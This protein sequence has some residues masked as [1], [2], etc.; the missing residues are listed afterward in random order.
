MTDSASLSDVAGVSVRSLRAA[1]GTALLFTTNMGLEDVAVDEWARRADAAG[2]EVAE[3]SP[4]T[5][6]PLDLN[7]YALVTVQAPLAAALEVARSMR[8][9]HHVRQPLYAFDL[10]DGTPA[11]ASLEAIREVLAAVEVPGMAEAGTFRVTSVRNGEHDFTSIDVQRASGTGLQRQ[12]ETEVDLE[13][14]DLD[15]HVDVH[16]ARCLVSVQHT[17]EA[18][19][20]RQERLFE[21]HAGLKPNVAYGLL[22]LPRLDA[23]PAVFLD[24][25]CGSGTLLVEAAAEWPDADLYGNDWDETVVEG[26][27]T[28]LRAEG[29]AGRVE[30]RD[31]DVWHLADAFADLAGTVDL[32]VTNPPFGRRIGRS[33]NFHTFYRRVLTQTADVLAEGGHL[34]ILALQHRAFNDALTATDRFDVRHVRVIGIGGL[35]PKAFVLRNA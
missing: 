24:P 17:R 31:A 23:P 34:V 29:L 19:S 26:V 3:E 5:P 32:M 33:M 1:D 10:P 18:L 15:V 12:Y 27:R 13:D 21:P 35:Y 9:V 6:S 25:F 11:E 2:L 30:V 14:Y 4:G 22:Q 28:N 8:S 7:S 20:R 16:D